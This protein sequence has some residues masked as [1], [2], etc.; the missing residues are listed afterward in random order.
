ME[1]SKRLTA[2]DAFRGFTIAGM[3]LVNNPGSWSYVYPP[4]RHAQWHG[5]T[6][7]DLVFP[8]F[9]FIVGVA[10]W[11][12]FKAFNYKLTQKAFN[13]IAK[14]TLLIFSIG[15]ALNAFPFWRNYDTLRIMGV[16]QRIALAYFFASML[17]LLFKRKT[18]LYL[19]GLILL[20]YWTIMYFAVPENPYNPETNF[21]R[22]VDMAVFGEK[23]VWNGFG[24]PF[25]PEG[26]LSTL[27]AIVTVILGYFTG[28]T[29][30]QSQSTEKAIL[31]MFVTG[32][33]LILAGMLWDYVFPINKALW[34]GSYVLYTGG[35]AM[36]FLALSIWLIDIKG[37]KL[38][39]QPLV[40]FGLNPLFIFVFS[41]LW[42][43]TLYLI[44][45]K[46]YD[47]VYN[48]LYQTA[49]VPVAGNMNGSLF[50]ALMHIV[51]FWL[52]V[53][54]LHKRKIYIKI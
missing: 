42:V 16:L 7:T 1:T 52:L 36:V 14:R 38:W 29:I 10:M 3:I 9:L 47:N 41:A 27:P 46:A 22:V 32:I 18:V 31:N 6:P 25:D 4:L 12:A 39:S 45:V 17:V 30:T 51:F 40:V 2:L 24:F 35:L 28:I 8:F 19:S 49:F 34:T 43:K 26:L 48:A 23:H 44:P 37:Y 5:C 50:F 15:L 13:K 54:I 33:P 20:I 11:F 53:Y 21:A